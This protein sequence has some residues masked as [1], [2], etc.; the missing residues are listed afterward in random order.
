[1]EYQEKG[2][3]QIGQSNVFNGKGA[4][5]QEIKIAEQGHVDDEGEIDGLGFD[6]G[7]ETIVIDKPGIVVKTVLPDR[8]DHAYHGGQRDDNDKSKEDPVLELFPYIEQ[9]D[10]DGKDQEGYPQGQHDQALLPVMREKGA[11]N[12]HDI[13]KD[14]Q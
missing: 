4:F 10:R 11:D 3:A 8:I 6:Q 1:M 7:G 5:A 12:M 14:H 9:P 13:K 2:D